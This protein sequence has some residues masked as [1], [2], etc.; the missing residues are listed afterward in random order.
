MS[1]TRLFQKVQRE[2]VVNVDLNQRRKNVV[3]TR[4]GKTLHLYR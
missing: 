3:F 4:G 2:A 1:A